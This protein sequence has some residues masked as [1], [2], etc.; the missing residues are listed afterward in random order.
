MSDQEKSREGATH[1][2]GP[3]GKATKNGAELC[4]VA[5]LSVEATESATN[6][7][8]LCVAVPCVCCVV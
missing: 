6:G 8:V 1:L 4:V 2:A 7:A 3:D 5:R